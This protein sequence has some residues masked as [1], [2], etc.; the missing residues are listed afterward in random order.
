V[1]E[2]PFPFASNEITPEL[3]AKALAL[4]EEMTQPV[5][6]TPSDAILAKEMVSALGPVITGEGALARFA[7]H[8]GYHQGQAYQIK[9][10]PGFPEGPAP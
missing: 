1:N 4:A 8:P 6:D 7:F 2:N 9:N 3:I 5:I 10:A